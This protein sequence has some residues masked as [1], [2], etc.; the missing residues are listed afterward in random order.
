MRARACVNVDGGCASEYAGACAVVACACGK[1]PGLCRG[2]RRK[3]CWAQPL[4]RGGILFAAPRREVTRRRWRTQVSESLAAT[5]AGAPWRA[6]STAAAAAPTPR[7]GSLPHGSGDEAAV[8]PVGPAEPGFAEFAAGLLAVCGLE[9]ED[10]GPEG[11]AM[12]VALS[13][14]LRRRSAGAGVELCRAGEACDRLVIVADGACAMY[15]PPSSGVAAA[16]DSGSEASA[17]ADDSGSAGGAAAAAVG[18]GAAAE[19]AAGGEAGGGGAAPLLWLGP[20]DSF[21]ELAL[22]FAG[23]HPTRVA[24]GPEGAR[25]L[26]LSKADLLAVVDRCG[27][28][29]RPRPFGV[30]FGM[31]IAV[32]IHPTRTPQDPLTCGRPAAAAGT[33]RSSTFSRTAPPSPTTPSSAAAASTGRQPPAPSAWRRR[34]R[35]DRALPARWQAGARGVPADAFASRR[36][37][38]T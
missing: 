26:E 29:C 13:G 20:G 16:D 6:A 38:S 5:A 18:E 23:S 28:R 10:L 36:M 3:G 2:P 30:R 8:G 34:A 33:R 4:R 14:C 22:V 27:R 1:Y 21:G 25:L 17:A 15:P 31:R 11:P 9:P 32:R 37:L 35:G 19:P 24:A 7:R 12:W